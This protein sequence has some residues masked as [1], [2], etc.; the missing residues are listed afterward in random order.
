M[1]K[2]LAAIIFTL[3]ISLTWILD[4]I[5]WF[6]IKDYRDGITVTIVLLFITIYGGIAIARSDE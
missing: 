3:F 5:F 2:R 1:S 6:I 4:I